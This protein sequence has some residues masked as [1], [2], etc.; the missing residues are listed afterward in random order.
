M[1]NFPIYLLLA[2]AL[3]SG[4]RIFRDDFIR[5]RN[6]RRVD[7]LQRLWDKHYN[8]RKHLWILT[9]QVEASTNFGFTEQLIKETDWQLYWHEYG[10][11]GIS[12][13]NALGSSFIDP[14]PEDE[15]I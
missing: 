13:S 11:H 15:I 1:N 2:A 3:W 12:P 7:R 6:Q 8:D 14:E 10:A 9:A 5:W 4:W